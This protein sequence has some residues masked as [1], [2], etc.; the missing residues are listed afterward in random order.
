M[1]PKATPAAAVATLSEALN[2]ALPA[3]G[4]VRAFDAMGFKPGDG[5]PAPMAKQIE[6][7][8]RI[9]PP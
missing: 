7:D 2:A 5:R 6:D 1:A 8:I 9:S 3:D 4:A